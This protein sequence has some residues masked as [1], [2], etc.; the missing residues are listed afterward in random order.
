[1]GFLE[2]DESQT[3]K[4]E[5]LS[6]SPKTFVTTTNELN[7]P[8]TYFTRVLTEITEAETKTDTEND[9]EK[10]YE[11]ER[12]IATQDSKR[13]TKTDI[14][15]HRSATNEYGRTIE[16]LA[17]QKVAS[18]MKPV[19]TTLPEEF[20]IVQRIPSDPFVDLPMVHPH[21]PEFDPGDCYTREWME[22]KPVDKDDF[23][24]PEVEKTEHGMKMKREIFQK[25]ISTQ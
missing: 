11:T 9:N 20:R 25:I 5:L 7:Q 15:S 19:T 1:M 4:G 2:T 12:N 6:R 21:P 10:A 14:D 24:Q 13:D 3:S 16:S 18:K 17:Y 23:L 22:S 8:S